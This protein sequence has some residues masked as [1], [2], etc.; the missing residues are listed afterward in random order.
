MSVDYANLAGPNGQEDNMGGLT[1]RAFFAPI[2][3][4]LS[5]KVPTGSPTAP[6][7]LVEITTAHTFTTGNCFLKAYCTA[8]KGKLD[9]KPQG[10]TDGKS[11]AQEGEIFLPGSKAEAHGFAAQA[12]NDNFIILLEEPDSADNGYLQVGTE[13]FPAKI[14]PEFTTGTNSSGV[15]GHIFKFK[16][17]TNRQY[18]YKAAVT[19]TPAS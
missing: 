17:M 13:M 9:V 11:F 8:D 2:G 5:I 18:I 12:K 6:E 1:Q 3:S 7:D 19:L 15:R 10:E 16:A 4:F 14:E